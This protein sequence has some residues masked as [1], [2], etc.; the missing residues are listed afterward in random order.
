[1]LEDDDQ[2]LFSKQPMQKCALGFEAQELGENQDVEYVKISRY[3]ER[4]SALEFRVRRRGQSLDQ[5]QLDQL[6]VARRVR[7]PVHK[8]CRK[9]TKDNE[10]K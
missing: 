3:D 4:A 7:E 6:P 10:N 8:S 5:Q 1:M 2:L 9:T